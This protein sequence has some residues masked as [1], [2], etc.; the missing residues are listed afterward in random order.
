MKSHTD[1]IVLDPEGPD[2]QG[3]IARIRERGPVTKV[4]LPGGVLAWSVT[5]T[6]MLKEIL[7]SHAVSKDPRQHWPAFREGRI[8][9]E[10]PLLNWVNTWSMFT[11]YGPDHRRLRAPLV[12]VFTDRRTAALE[13]RIQAIA[14]DLVTGLEART[15]GEPVDIRE[16]FAYPLPLRVIN[17]LMGVPQQLI[18]PLRKCVDGI[19][20]VALSEAEAVANYHAMIGLLQELV[21]YR[22]DNPAEDM[23]STLI[24][25]ADDPATV[26]SIEELIGTLYLTINAGHETT[27]DL[28]D[29]AVFLLLTHPD[30]L[31]A[32]LDGTL[33]WSDVIE[34]TLRFEPSIAHAPLRYAV[35]DFVLGDV[36]ITA[37]DPILSCPAGANRDPKV[38]GDSAGTF[39]PT[40]TN[41]GHMAFGHGPHRCPGAPLARLEALVGLPALFQ[42]FP[43]MK[44][45]VSPDELGAVPGFIANGHDRLPVFL[46]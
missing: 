22:R 39:D 11:A 44:L 20:D 19:F 32:A 5:D 46:R 4:V 18:E 31:A 23:T 9:T 43:Q 33:S 24:A 7:S 40:R 45:A 37:G 1:P 28:L 41:K 16:H 6:A 26:F 38:Y 3:E 35:T 30:H 10:F 21:T 29:Q 34:E 14:D 25:H 36:A 2:I 27:V 12:P 17:E 8:G 13:P 15:G 42:A